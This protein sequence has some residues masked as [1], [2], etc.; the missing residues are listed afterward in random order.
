MAVTLYAISIGT[1]LAVANG[2]LQNL[3]AAYNA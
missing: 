3:G 1:S 2:A